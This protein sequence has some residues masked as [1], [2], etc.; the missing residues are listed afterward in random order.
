MF[1]GVDV[2]LAL[3]LS[4][5]PFVLPPSLSSLTLVILSASS[6][7]VYALLSSLSGIPLRQ[8]LAVTGSV[9]QLGTNHHPLC[10]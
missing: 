1:N 4:T 7:E 5:A 8:D 9:S 2:E 10:S 6:T 3:P